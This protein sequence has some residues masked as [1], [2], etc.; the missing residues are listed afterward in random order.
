MSVYPAWTTMRAYHAND[1]SLPALTHQVRTV[2]MAPNTDP[3]KYIFNH[4]MYDSL[5]LAHAAYDPQDTC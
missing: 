3:S 1:N 5:P 2:T 4:T